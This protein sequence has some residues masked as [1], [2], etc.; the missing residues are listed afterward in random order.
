[1]RLSSSKAELM[2]RRSRWLAVR[3]ARTVSN[4]LAVLVQQYFVYE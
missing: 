4:V 1:M 2:Q 3:E